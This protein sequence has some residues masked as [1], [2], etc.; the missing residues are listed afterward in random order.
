M[1]EAAIYYLLTTE[2]AVA[3]LVSDRVFPSY[4]PVN[5]PM[6]AVTYQVISRLERNTVASLEDHVH[7]RY[8]IQVDCIARDYDSL[9]ALVAAVRKAL[10][11][12]RGDFAGATVVTIR[13]EFQSLDVYNEDGDFYTRTSDFL[14][15]LSEP[16]G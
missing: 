10:A 4:L 9:V 12:K 13:P 8:R 3:A 16:V 2:P 7:V 5:T 1:M 15:T 6:P 14:A 11:N